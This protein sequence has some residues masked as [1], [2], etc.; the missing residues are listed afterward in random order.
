MD[1]LPENPFSRVQWMGLA[2]IIGFFAYN[3]VYT[4]FKTWMV[5]QGLPIETVVTSGVAIGLGPFTGRAVGLL[6]ENDALDRTPLA[7]QTQPFREPSTLS[8][9]SVWRASF[10]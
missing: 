3:S 1:H 9:Y 4:S 10:T 8:A 5:E 7:R 6:R 2:L